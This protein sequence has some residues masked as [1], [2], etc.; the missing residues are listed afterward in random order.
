MIAMRV[1][2][3][4]YGSRHPHGTATGDRRAEA[5]QAAFLHEQL[6]RCCC[7]CRLPTIV[8]AGLSAIGIEVQQKGAATDTRCLGLDKIQHQLYGDGGI[9]RAAAGIENLQPGLHRKRVRCSDHV[10]FGA[11]EN[12]LAATAGRL[13]LQRTQFLRPGVDA[14]QQEKTGQNPG[15]PA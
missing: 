4:P 1:S 11:R 7:R 14:G 3:Q 6:R 10:L 12:F 2:Q 8:G 9:H 5:H 15:Q 13:G